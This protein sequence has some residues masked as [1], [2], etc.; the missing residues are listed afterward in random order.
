MKLEEFWGDLKWKRRFQRQAV[1]K[2][3]RL[4]LFLPEIAHYG[5]R[6]I[7]IFQKFFAGNDKTF[8]LAGRLDSRLPF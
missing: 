6:L 8:I 2:Y 5:K 7:T 4:T 3:F 1:A